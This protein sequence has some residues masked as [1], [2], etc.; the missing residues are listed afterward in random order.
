MERFSRRIRW[1]REKKARVCEILRLM[2][3]RYHWPDRSQPFAWEK[4][5]VIDWI[6]NG[7][8]LNLEDSIYAYE[9]AKD[10][11]AILF[12]RQTLLWRGNPDWT[13]KLYCGKPRR[14]A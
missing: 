5:E 2:T 12:D 10:L 9:F 8:S 6:R 7:V 3:P 1:N 4:S 13:E 14:G 11:K